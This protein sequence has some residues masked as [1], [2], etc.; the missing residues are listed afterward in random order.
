M[1]DSDEFYLKPKQQ[2]QS[3]N[4]IDRLAAAL[5]SAIVAEE[6]QDDYIDVINSPDFFFL[7]LIQ[8]DS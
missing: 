4:D 1:T 7:S 3:E 6:I 8:M 2:L 5:V